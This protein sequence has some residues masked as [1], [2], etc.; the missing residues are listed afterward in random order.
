VV[1]VMGLVP[2]T[3]CVVLAVGALAVIVSWRWVHRRWLQWVL[4]AGL[5]AMA[6]FPLLYR[7]ISQR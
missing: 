4:A 5:M 6:A 1:S 7:S 3:V 2:W